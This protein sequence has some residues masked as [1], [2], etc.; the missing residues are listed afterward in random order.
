MKEVRSE[1]KFN[2]ALAEIREIT[3]THEEK[4]KVLE[5]ILNTAS[6]EEPPHQS[7]IFLTHSHAFFIK[8]RKLRIFFSTRFR[9]L[10]IHHKTGLE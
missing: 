1:E 2:K 9:P 4:E 5:K 6:D 7:R 10:G 8:L 3:L